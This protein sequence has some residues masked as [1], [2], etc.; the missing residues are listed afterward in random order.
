VPP[1][2]RNPGHGL[3]F[4][5]WSRFYEWTPF[6]RRA[7]FRLQDEAVATLDPQR[8]QRVLDLGCGPARG[9]KELLERGA[10]PVAADYSAGMIAKAAEQTGSRAPIVRLDAMRLPFRA[11]V[12]DAILCTNSFHHYPEPRTCVAEMWRVLR[13]GGRLVLVDP[14]GESAVSRLMVHVGEG[15]LFG[16]E[17]VHV[18]T[19][20][21]WVAML[22]EA[23]FREIS[24]TRGRGISPVR[25]AEVF[26]SAIA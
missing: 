7:L 21:E 25:R 19:D 20:V 9:T 8:G 14:S 2:G 17:G 1:P 3:F 10:R 11:H 16:L 13:P 26:V 5:V 22:R 23:G 4:D 6:L 24:A 18:H 12:F 15:F